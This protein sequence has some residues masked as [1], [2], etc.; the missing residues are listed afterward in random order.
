MDVTL[1]VL[2]VDDEWR[3]SIVATVRRRSEREG[4]ATAVVQPGE[5]AFTGDEFEAAVLYTIG[6]E[7][8]DAVLLDVRF[9]EHRDDRCRGLG[10]LRNLLA[11]C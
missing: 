4:W 6:E 8:P 3:S 5:G 10:I 1:K 2:I 11:G 7:R 9:G